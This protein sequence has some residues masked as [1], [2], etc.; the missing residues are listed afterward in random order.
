VYCAYSASMCCD[1]ADSFDMTEWLESLRSSFSCADVMAGGGKDSYC[2]RAM[3]LS[4]DFRVVSMFCC[5]L[6]ALVEAGVFADE[7]S[8]SEMLTLG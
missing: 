2:G 3:S 7:Y 1:F 6:L 5:I 8:R 4:D